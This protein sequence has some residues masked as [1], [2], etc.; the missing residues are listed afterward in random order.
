MSEFLELMAHVA[1]S[2][3]GLVLALCSLAL[4]IVAIR[5]SPMR[6]YRRFLLFPLSLWIVVSGYSAMASNSTGAALAGVF[7]GLLVLGVYALVIAPLVAK[8]S[9]PRTLIVVS[10]ALF[11]LQLPLSF[12]SAIYLTC[13]LAHDCL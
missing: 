3:I 5:L 7:W 12:L 9:A 10:I 4:L 6:A 8:Q 11:V 13:Y 2:R 1:F